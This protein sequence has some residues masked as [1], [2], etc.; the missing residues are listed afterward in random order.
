MPPSFGPGPRRCLD[1]PVLADTAPRLEPD[2]GADELVL[3]QHALG[4]VDG[5]AHLDLA[6]A[7]VAALADDAGGED[8][9]HVEL[10]DEVGDAALRQDVGAGALAQ[11]LVDVEDLAGGQGVDALV[12]V[13]LLAED[14]G[15]E[16][17]LALRSEERR[18][19][20]EC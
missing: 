6:G 4:A 20:K 15:E 19:G 18:V 9:Q 12:L 13:E 7:A 16:D 2:D 10:A 8:A 3:L 14:G 17:E 5:A 11:L 1:E